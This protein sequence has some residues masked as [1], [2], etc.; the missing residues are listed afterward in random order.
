MPGQRFYALESAS[1][2]ISFPT[3]D[4]FQGKPQR[5]GTS[6]AARMMPWAW[7]KC[8]AILNSALHPPSGKR[9]SSLD[10]VTVNELTLHDCPV[11]VSSISSSGV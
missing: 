8:S 1:T 3:Y 4:H 7:R 6:S 5:V 10:P 9:L 11:Q 2:S